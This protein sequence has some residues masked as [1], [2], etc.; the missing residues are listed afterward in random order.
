[1]TTEHYEIDPQHS[2]IG[3]S[4]RHLAVATVR[5]NFAKFSGGVDLTDGNPLSAKGSAV[6][7][8]DSVYTGSEQRDGHLKSAD[9]FDAEK[10]PTM[11]Y[12]VT[13]VE[14]VEGET[15]KVRGNLTI[16]DVAKPIELEASVD[17]RVPDPFGGNE[18]VGIT[19]TGK[20]DRMEFGLNWDG[21]AGAIPLASH[22]IKLQIDLAVVSKATEPATA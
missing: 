15:Y 8:I 12:E 19:V 1:M 5:G 13:G 17:G 14:L 21:L 7:E 11:K 10:Y 9:F 3:F 22:T 4:A 20:L 6:I 2:T 18:R 16:R